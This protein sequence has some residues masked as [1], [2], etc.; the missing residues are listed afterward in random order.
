MTNIVGKL[1]EVCGSHPPP[2][3]KFPFLGHGTVQKLDKT[4]KVPCWAVMTT[5]VQVSVQHHTLHRL[6]SYRGGV[7][8]G[9]MEVNWAFWNGIHGHPKPTITKN[10]HS[11]FWQSPGRHEEGASETPKWVFEKNV[12]RWLMFFYQEQCVGYDV[13]FKTSIFIRESEI[14]TCLN[15][16]VLMCCCVVVSSCVDVCCGVVLC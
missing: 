8:S 2:N 12:A 11:E 7:N 10:R 14:P 16:C 4:Y 5:N 6:S 3:L 1:C 15:P 9:E 13:R